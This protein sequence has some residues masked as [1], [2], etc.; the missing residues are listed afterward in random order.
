[1]TVGREN[2]PNGTWELPVSSGAAAPGQPRGSETAASGEG[3]VTSVSGGIDTVGLQRARTSCDP[4][5]TTWS[6]DSPRNERTVT[7]PFQRFGPAPFAPAVS[8]MCSGRA[9]TTTGAPTV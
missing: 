2:R 1:M 8:P 9:A 7:V 5:E 4:T 6:T 3:S